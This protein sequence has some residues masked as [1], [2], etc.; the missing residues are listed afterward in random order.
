MARCP[1]EGSLVVLGP[2]RVGASSGR[3]LVLRA[4]SSR[5][6]A[7][8]LRG[9]RL[10]LGLAL[11]CPALDCESRSSSDP[12]R[13][14]GESVFCPSRN[15][16]S[17]ERLTCLLVSYRPL[18][19]AALRVLALARAISAAL[20]LF[21]HGLSYYITS[22]TAASQKRLRKKSCAASSARCAKTTSQGSRL[23]NQCSHNTS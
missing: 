4:Y 2:W 6:R 10:R 7:A 8:A 9:Q 5:M 17:P 16:A 22:S 1:G 3:A 15:R 18:A 20:A 23:D 14:A 12:S 11:L 21:G 19:S 13:A